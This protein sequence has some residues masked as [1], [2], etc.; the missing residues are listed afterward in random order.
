MNPKPP[1]DTLNEQVGVLRRREIEARILKPFVAAL[2]ERF[3]EA[4]V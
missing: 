3:G 4:A 2:S 1:P